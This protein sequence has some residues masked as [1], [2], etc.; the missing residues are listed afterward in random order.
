[1]ELAPQYVAP[2]TDTETQL[3]QIW[4]EVL[5]VERIGIHDNFFA[6]GGDS[7]LAI[8]V[9]SRARQH[10]FTL[11][12]REIFQHQTVATLVQVATHTKEI[13]PAERGGRVGIP[14]FPLAEIDA[15]AIEQLL[16]EDPSIEDIYPVAP[17]Q[18]GMLF[19]TLMQPGTGVYVMQDRY[20]LCG[21]IDV[22]A[23][24]E[25]WQW[26]AD[27]HP[28]LRTSFFWRTERRP[29]QLVHRDVK[30]PFEYFDWR[31]LP[32]TEQEGRLE[33]MLETERRAGFDLACA[34][35]LRIRLIRLEGR[36]YRCVRSFHHI[37]LDEWCTSPL[38][39][40]FRT[41]YLALVQ[42]QPPPVLTAPPFRDYIAWLQGQDMDA[43]ER[44]WGG[45]LRDFAEPT[46]VLVDRPS[47][48][49]PR[50]KAD[51]KEEGSEEV[52]VADTVA[53]LSA[54]DTEALYALAKREQ[55][56]ANTLVQAAWALVLSR[57]SGRNEVLFG[58]T[59]AGRPWTLPGIEQTLGLFVNS[60][61]LRVRVRPE[62]NLCEW[63]RELLAANLELRQY[64][65]APLVRIQS[66]SEIPR[67]EPLFNHLLVFE[68]TPVDPSL[69]EGTDDLAVDY[70]GN[71][72]H[73][74]YPITL[75]VLPG[76]QLSLKITYARD[77]FE[78]A[79]VDRMLGHFNHLLEE[80]IRR[81]GSCLGELRMLGEEECRQALDRWNR[82]D[83]PYPSP[84]DFVASF[85]QQVSRL[86]D[87]V[88]VICGDTSLS[89][90]ALNARAHQ[91]AHALVGR[92]VGA[93]L[94]VAVLDER[95]IDL[96][97]AILAILKAGGAYLPLDPSH[98]EARG[99]QVIRVSR[100][101]LVL[102]GEAW[103]A[104]ITK[105]LPELEQSYLSVV[106]MAELVGEHAAERDPAPCRDPRDL[107]YIIFTS[108]STGVPKG[109]MVE[110]RGMFNNLMT[111]VPALGLTAADVIAQTAPQCF[112]ISV[113][114]F[115]TPLICGARIQILPDPITRDPASLL[116]ALNEKGITILESVPTLIEAMLDLPG[117]VTPLPNLRWLLPTGEACSPAICRRWRERYPHVALLNAY[118]PAECADDVAYHRITVDDEAA[119]RVP[120]GRPVDNM[121]LYILDRTLQPAP[122][123]VP[124][125]L[126]VA[127]V[128]VGRGYLKRPDL[129]AAAFI[130]DLFGPPGTRLYRTG[131]LACYRPD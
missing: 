25:A 74:N 93:D 97:V 27:H 32:A 98:P 45:Y 8:Q 6:L 48:L 71:R 49:A 72:V 81:P 3:A 47:R 68:N 1:A 57:Y 59:V 85:E 30:L 114:Q 84:A 99:L 130:P 34:P 83:Q 44:F 20:E 62:Q 76:P 127:G 92:G 95:G 123:D 69:R 102:T 119:A 118:G 9:A 22:G 21:R 73:T 39:L 120:I 33:A 126:C 60:L 107:A 75:T 106:T 11:T 28:I 96:L 67:G 124:G 2:R 66:W 13:G 51:A 121:R 101:P 105:A 50:G 78:A 88:A 91:V 12:P 23:F 86:P 122:V 54:G 63:L 26:V 43:A 31:G 90:Q 17:M 16:V 41:G 52:G 87:T 100:A 40:D 103:Q 113:W 110:R 108:G 4:A 77:R 35:L 53:E 109:A 82:T 70:L 55:V 58:V 15:D 19:H 116:R 117:P 10:G 37:L 128:G 94:I 14:R 56:T 125:E 36:R 65:Y 80:M 131:D 111:K 7:I 61:P 79:V 18:E 29:H 115:L 89:Y 46:P 38:W 64:E 104:R 129:T 5:R 112:D 24:H 42:G